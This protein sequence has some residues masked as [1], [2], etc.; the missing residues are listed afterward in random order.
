MVIRRKAKE[1]E[2]EVKKVV[3]KKVEPEEEPATEKGENQ[4]P[5]IPNYLDL[6][7]GEVNAIRVML[8]KQQEE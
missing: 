7:L 1:E 2:E 3:K 4:I 8:E 5:M 6:I